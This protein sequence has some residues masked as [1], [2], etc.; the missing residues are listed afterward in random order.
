[1]IGLL[2]EHHKK[3]GVCAHLV[4][5]EIDWF[6]KSVIVVQIIHHILEKNI[7]KKVQS[8]LK[9]SSLDNTINQK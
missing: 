9:T 2:L 6:L 8:S 7:L 3:V 4:G 5:T 1:M